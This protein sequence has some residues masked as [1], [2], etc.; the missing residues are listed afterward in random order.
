MLSINFVYRA[1]K[2]RSTPPFD[3]IFPLLPT[4]KKKIFKKSFELLKTIRYKL[5]FSAEF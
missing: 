4:V 1:R 3:N 5:D 2:V